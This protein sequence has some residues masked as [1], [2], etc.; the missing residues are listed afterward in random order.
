[1]LVS[2]NASAGYDNGNV[3]ARAFHWSGRQT[4]RVFFRI[5]A[6][7]HAGTLSPGNARFVPL[8]LETQFLGGR[9]V[10]FSLFLTCKLAQFRGRD[11][12]EFNKTAAVSSTKFQDI[13]LLL[14]NF[15]EFFVRKNPPPSFIYFVCFQVLIHFFFSPLFSRIFHPIFL[16][17]IFLNRREPVFNRLYLLESILR[18]NLPFYKVQLFLEKIAK[19]KSSIKKYRESC[20]KS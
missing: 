7:T 16:L 14:W 18:W 8:Q 6:G 11:T 1:M 9:P 5:Y 12:R 19:W 15:S 13:F 17:L 10:L 2:R 3:L 4:E 20:D